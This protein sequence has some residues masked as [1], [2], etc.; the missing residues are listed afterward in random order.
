MSENV[1]DRF[2]KIGDSGPPV[3]NV[4]GSVRTIGATVRHNSR[5]AQGKFKP[6]QNRIVGPLGPPG[7]TGPGGVDSVTGQWVPGIQDRSQLHDLERVA[8]CRNPYFQ[9][10][11]YSAGVDPARKSHDGAAEAHAVINHVMS[12][13]ACATGG[14]CNG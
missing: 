10:P 11:D 4:S 6:R 2:P 14:A 13:P 9:V 3:D 5:G 8:A 7:G 1:T 12:C